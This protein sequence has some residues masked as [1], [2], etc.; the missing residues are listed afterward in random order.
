[1]RAQVKPVPRLLNEKPASETGHGDVP[2][3][4]SFHAARVHRFSIYVYTLPPSQ[5][6]SAD[7]KSI[8]TSRPARF[9]QNTIAQAQTIAV[10]KHQKFILA[11]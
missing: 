4:D 8:W 2:P 9:P 11:V 6:R 10:R 7:L 3:E 1:M 5:V